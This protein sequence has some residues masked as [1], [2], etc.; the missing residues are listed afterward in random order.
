MD[1][2]IA[3][4]RQTS[5]TASFVLATLLTGASGTT[6]AQVTVLV[7]TDGDLQATLALPGSV[8]NGK[9]VYA[10]CQSCHR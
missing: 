3:N 1:N 2:P 6:V 4:V 5:A 10:E 8:Q 9:E 7:P